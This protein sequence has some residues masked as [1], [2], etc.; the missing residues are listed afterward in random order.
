MI[1]GNTSRTLEVSTLF[2]PAMTTKNGSI[3]A[4]ET[5]EGGN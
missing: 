5:S 4:D 3:V 1:D 2:R